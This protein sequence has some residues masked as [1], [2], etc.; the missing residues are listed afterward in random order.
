MLTYIYMGTDT[1][2]TSGNPLRQWGAVTHWSPVSDPWR[3]GTKSADR[4]YHSTRSMRSMRAFYAWWI[5][6][7]P[8]TGVVVGAHG[9]ACGRCHGHGH[10]HGIFILA[11][12]P[13]C[14]RVGLCSCRHP[15]AEPCVLSHGSSS[16]EAAECGPGRQLWTGMRVSVT[17]YLLQGPQ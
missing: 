12:H 16:M 6:F 15:T 7:S 11:T 10:G 14:E 4:G 17:A 2:T 8:D 3:G 5:Y 13:W 9:K 1:V